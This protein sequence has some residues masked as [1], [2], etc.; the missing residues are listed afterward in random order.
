ME[1]LITY[2][3]STENAAGRKRLRLVAK[4]CEGY[5]Q[6]VQKSVFECI[7]NAAQFEAL[8]AKLETIVDPTQDSLRI[9]R[10]LEPRERYVQVIGV[11]PLHDLHNPLIL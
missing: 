11:R 9:Y 8:R 3:V 10:L 6:R 5:G 1:V 7:V 2:D 4:A